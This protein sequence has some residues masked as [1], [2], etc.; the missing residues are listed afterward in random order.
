[1]LRQC[2]GNILNILRKYPSLGKRPKVAVPF[3]LFCLQ[4]RR[5]GLDPWVRK[6]P[7]RRKWQPTPVLL[8]GKSH[9]QRSLVDYSAWGLK[10]SDTTE[11]LHFIS[12]AEEFYYSISSPVLRYNSF[13]KNSHSRGFALVTYIVSVVET[14]IFL[15]TNGVEQ[16][17]VFSFT[18]HTYPLVTFF[19]F[20]VN[21][22]SVFFCLIV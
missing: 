20:C 14:C 21:L 9:G 18:T 6:I 17:F 1:M 16:L 15:M 8:P 10:E 22:K 12:S 2:G 13:F 7:W 5:P 3:C 11:R 4:C 19:K